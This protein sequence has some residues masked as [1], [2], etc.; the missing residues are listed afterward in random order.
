MSLAMYLYPPERVIDPH[1]SNGYCALAERITD[2]RYSAAEIPASGTHVSVLTYTVVAPG[3]S[4]PCF[5]FNGRTIAVVDILEAK[6]REKKMV[7][8]AG[9]MAKAIES[10]G[11]VALYGIYF[12]FNKADLKPDLMRRCRRWPSC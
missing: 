7:T 11:R 4:D 2:Q 9:A 5:G 6:D 10:S 8:D 3:K 12:D 1:G